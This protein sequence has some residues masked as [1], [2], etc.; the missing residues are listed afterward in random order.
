MDTFFAVFPF[1]VVAGL[2]ILERRQ[3]RL[4]ANALSYRDFVNFAFGLTSFGIR[5]FF[6]VYLLLTY[7]NFWAPFQLFSISHLELPIWAIFI[8]G[9]LV[10]DMAEYWSH[11]IQHLIHPFWR[12]HRLHH[13][14]EKVDALTTFL[15]H[16]L[17]VVVSTALM[18]AVL[19]LFDIPVIVIIVYGLA[20]GFLSALS[21]ADLLFSNPIDRWISKVF[22]TSNF[23]RIHHSLDYAESNS[24]Y[25]IVFSFWDYLFLTRRVKAK[26]AL[27]FQRNGLDGK[28]AP[29]KPSFFRYIINPFKKMRG[30]KHG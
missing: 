10:L 12:L 27:S 19:V 25:G 3:Q 18:T 6:S 15:H 30:A 5:Y 9:F 28:Q 7:V 4:L 23:H 8:I 14:D 17:E 22:V 2:L 16:P 24:N 29:G 13:S 1:A 11:R 21:H 26:E 20:A